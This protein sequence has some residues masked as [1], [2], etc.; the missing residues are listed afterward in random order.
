MNCTEVV[1]P[2]VLS[3]FTAAISAILIVVTVPG[4]LLVLITVYKD[5]NNDLRT[6]FCLYVVNLA[7]SDLIVGCVVEP[8]SVV[9]HFHEGFRAGAAL[10]D[11]AVIHMSYF[12]SCTASVLSLAALT[13]DRFLAVEWPV[14]Y[15]TKLN[16][17]HARVVSLSIWLVSFTISFIYFQVGYIEYAFVFANTSICFTLFTLVFAYLRILNKMRT[18]AKVSASLRAG[19]PNTRIRLRTLAREDRVTKV[20]IV[21]IAAYGCCYAPTC[22]LIYL[23][24]FCKSCSC[25]SIHWFR[26]MQFLF[27]LLNS[28]LNPF[29]Y[30]WRLSSFKSAFSVILRRYS[31]VRRASSLTSA[32]NLFEQIWD[33]RWKLHSLYTIEPNAYTV[34]QPRNSSTAF[35]NRRKTLSFPCNRV[36]SLFTR[37]EVVRKISETSVISSRGN[38]PD[39]KDMANETQISL[40]SSG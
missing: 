11:I 9:F 15:R 2:S 30:S 7:V 16:S 5:P 31:R 6:P 28:S 19:L 22:V 37:G 23:M 24:N 34:S 40:Q 12:I 35:T 18:Q 25:Y 17:I 33:I 36:N 26:D 14:K 38:F 39:K 20:F 13:F 3:Y 4:N 27:V 10:G 29:L 8:M 21:V 1:A 32:S